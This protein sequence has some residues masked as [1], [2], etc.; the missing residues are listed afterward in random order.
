[1]GPQAGWRDEGLIVRLEFPLKQTGAESRELTLLDQFILISYSI[2]IVSEA[3]WAN[4]EKESIKSV[5]KH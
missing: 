2:K 4:T 3:N 5:G 1:M